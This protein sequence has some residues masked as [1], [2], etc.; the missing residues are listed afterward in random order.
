MFFPIY[1][2]GFFAAV[3]L[4]VGW[5]YL[6][7]R[8]QNSTLVPLFLLIA[9][10]AYAWGVF[11]GPGGADI[12]LGVVFRDLAILGG[13]GFIFQFL[14]KRSMAF[15]IGL[16][17]LAAG[18]YG[19][20]QNQMKLSF[21][22]MEQS[23]GSILVAPEGE[24]LVELAEG[25]KSL[26]AIQAI[27]DNYDLQLRPAF[28]PEDREATELDDYYV[29]DIPNDRA[30]EL[31]SVIEALEAN[32]VVDW[33]EINEQVSVTPMPA[34]KLPAIN[35]KFGI[36]DP[37]LDQLW[38]FEAMEVDR[39]YTLLKTQNVQPKKKALIAI[40]DTGVDAK[41]EDLAGKFKSIKAKYDKD[42]RGHGTHCAGIA[43]AITNNNKGIASF[44]PDD[45][46][47]QIT[48]IKVLSD[49]GM[50]SQKMIIDG[51]LEAAD[52]G[53]DVISMSLGG[54]SSAMKQRAY[55]KAVAYANKKGVIV[56]AA[57]GN[58]N[59]NAKD[60]APVNTPGV[61]GV[62][63]IDSRLNLATFSNYVTDIKWG[64]AAPGVGIY[65]TI[66][67]SGYAAYNG[68]SM[69]TPYVAGLVGLMKSIK[70]DI[71]TE[72]VYTLLNKTGKRTQQTAKSGK[73][74]YPEKVIEQL[75]K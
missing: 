74:I 39:L 5:F 20:Y 68:T 7:A 62:S 57:A 21:V 1:A 27:S 56:L 12:K 23:E 37:G 49:S 28:Q 71:T 64:V 33:V 47:T 30:A 72:E 42:V 58:S 34:K 31:Q 8:R 11:G 63:A 75:I 46:F 48:S 15:V 22:S 43:G 67:N 2:I 51:I 19:Y 24:L 73:L 16:I 65:S 38:G 70:P 69:A 40:L 45:R 32:S 18:L 14:A 13:I 25:S 55:Q 59:R 6:Q 54:R 35:K 41:H 26:D 50:G 52:K 36:N 3:L 53:A 29:V 60:Y 61:I 66:P 17:I 10:V 9:L 4:L 44:S